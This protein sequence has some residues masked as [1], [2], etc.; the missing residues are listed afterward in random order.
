MIRSARVS[1][2]GSGLTLAACDALLLLGCYFLAAVWTQ[3]AD[4]NTYLFY[5]DGLLRISVVVACF[6]IGLYFERLYEHL[7]PPARL[8]QEVCL[9]MGVCFFIQAVLTYGNWGLE[10]ERMQMIYASLLVLPLFPAWRLAFA[11][12]RSRAIPVRRTL[13]LGASPALEELALKLEEQPEIGISVLGYLDS[14]VVPLRGLPKLGSLD[15]FDAVVRDYSPRLVVIGPVEEEHLLPVRRLLE[16]QTGGLQVEEAGRLYESVI[17]RVSTLSM[18]PSP[19]IFSSQF[20]P[21]PANLAL[22]N[23]Y[24]VILAAV[25]V[26]VTSPVMVLCAAL[27]KLSSS[28]PVFTRE[29]R[30]GVGGS[31]LRTLGFRT[32]SR[33]GAEEVVTRVGQGLRRLHLDQLPRLFNVVKGDLSLVGPEPERAEFAAILERNIPLYRYRHVVKPGLTGWAQIHA[34]ASRPF[35]DTL[36][37]LEYDF[38]YI[39]NLSVSLDARIL[40]RS[41]TPINPARSAVR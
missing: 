2:R 8:F 27:V 1:I 17:G 10:L 22:Q 23:L 30:V 3:T 9:V 40:L 25:A 31:R 34:D 15:N 37:K 21:S 29:L 32:S 18:G 36:V 12:V 38:Y 33:L 19:V 28:G 20:D 26:L 24:S 35:E 16:M 7:V 13:F 11:A 41:L 5:D 39:K 4:L 6:Q 14:G